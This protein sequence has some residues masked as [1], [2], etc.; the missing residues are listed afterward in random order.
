MF[1]K[2][3]SVFNNSC[4]FRALCWSNTFA[5]TQMSGFS[6]SI[7]YV[8]ISVV[9]SGGPVD[10][11]RGGGVWRFQKSLYI[12]SVKHTFSQIF[13][14]SGGGEVGD[15][16]RHS[17]YCKTFFFLGVRTKCCADETLM[18]IYAC[19]LRYLHA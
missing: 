8:C 14:N 4:L 12:S 3:V 9:S 19:T 5:T 16:K 1:A 11:P 18:Y 6:I 7:P 10:G 13:D 2:T 15:F 17:I